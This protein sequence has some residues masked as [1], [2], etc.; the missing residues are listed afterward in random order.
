MVFVNALSINSY[1][2][3]HTPYLTPHNSSSASQHTDLEISRERVSPFIFNKVIRFDLDGMHPVTK[4]ENS[5]IR[6]SE[7]LTLNS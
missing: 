5:K 4:V 7:F 1:P 6:F 3:P 2:T